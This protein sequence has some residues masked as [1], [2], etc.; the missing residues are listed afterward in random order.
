MPKIEVNEGLFFALS[1]APREP[2]ALEFAL[3]SG[4]AE[5]DGWDRGGAPG[6][7][8]LKIELND[9]NRPDLWSTAGIARLLRVYAGGAAPRYDFFSAKGAMKDAGKRHVVVDPALKDIRPYIAAFVISGKPIDQ[10]TLDD[11]IQ[12]QEKLCWNFGRKRKAIAMGVYRSSMIEWP[13]RYRAADPLATRFVPLGMEE[14]L[15]LREICERHP[16]G[17]E[18]GGIVEGF[19]AYPYLE[20]SRGETLSFPPVIN[21]ARI[22][23]VQAGDTDLFVEMTGTELRSLCL[24]ASIVACDFADMGY[25]ILPVAVEYPY[26]TE[27]GRLPSFPYYFQEGQ[28]ASMAVIRKVL[29]IDISAAEAVAALAKMG[30]EAKAEG[31]SVSIRCPEY[32]NDFLHAV[33]IA[34]DVIIGRGMTSFEPETPSDYTVGRLK[35]LEVYGRRLKDGLVGLGYQEMI[36]NY[37]DSRKNLIERM[38]IDAAS[39]ARISNPMSE[40]FEYVRNS[41]LPSLLRAEAAS[42][43]AP[44]PHKVFEL[45]KAVALDPAENYGTRTL[46]LLS[47]LRADKEA[48]YNDIAADAAAILYYAGIEWSPRES[49]DPRF[50]AGRQAELMAGGKVLGI[51]G[52]IHPAVLEAWGIGMPCAAFELDVEAMMAARGR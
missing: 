28:R 39:V 26:D 18:Y 10:E 35:P 3:T 32:R 23:A 14:E 34:E 41:A 16:K 1:K 6:E 24:A 45:G 36:F 44:Y 47:A 49:S 21:S 50:I 11:I 30:V 8:V 31:D 51:L 42:Q 43:S 12:T 52:E 19:K 17:Q 15:S 37:L 46:T 48:S 22:G 13:V 2:E 40:S 38:G 27:F 33:D 4:K 25:S 20:D 5:L 7:G 29:G 9:T